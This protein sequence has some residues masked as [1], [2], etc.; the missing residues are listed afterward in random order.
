[1]KTLP[2]LLT[3]KE[4]SGATDRKV[5][6]SAIRRAVRRGELTA[7][8]TTDSCCAKILIDA[9]DLANWLRGKCAGRNIVPSPSEVAAA[10][11]AADAAERGA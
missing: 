7:I 1:M 11:A 9:D 10:N 3:I 8:R 4:A 5:P 6:E 2:T